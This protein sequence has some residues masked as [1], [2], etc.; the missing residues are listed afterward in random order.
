LRSRIALTNSRAEPG[1]GAAVVGWPAIALLAGYGCGQS[2]L[3]PVG[4]HV[5]D[6]HQIVELLLELRHRGG[7]VLGR[8][9][10]MGAPPLVDSSTASRPQPGAPGA[11]NTRR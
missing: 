2:G 7:R 11:A 10:L 6:R 5:D 3:E 4:E 9:G 1:G 8:R